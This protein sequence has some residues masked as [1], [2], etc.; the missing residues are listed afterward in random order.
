MA[1]PFVLFVIFPTYTRCRDFPWIVSAGGA[2]AI[3]TSPGQI[4][5]WSLLVYR[6]EFVRPSGPYV[7][8][9]LTQSPVGRFSM[10][11][12]EDWKKE[13]RSAVRRENWSLSGPNRVVKVSPLQVPPR[14]EVD[15]YITTGQF[16]V[17]KLPSQIECALGLPLN[18]LCFGA[19]IYR[20]L[21]L[22]MAHEYEYELTA[23]F[24][25]GLA[26][27][28][29]HSDPRYPA[30]SNKIHQWRIKKGF[31]VAVDDAASLVLH[32]GQR[33]PYN[34]LLS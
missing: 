19:R 13:V 29:A 28:P 5:S 27:N 7:S 30:G 8:R 24:P 26:F 22:P 1:F 14:S 18:Y 10:A 3:E 31:A 15:G 23:R 34:W 4:D 2:R 6:V 12:Q 20:L 16:L 33:F 32:P 9:L 25:D 11:R 21:R 17:G